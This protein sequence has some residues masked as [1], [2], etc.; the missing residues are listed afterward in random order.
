MRAHLGFVGHG[1]PRGFFMRQVGRAMGE[2]PRLLR[3]EPI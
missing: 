2:V 3:G 1:A